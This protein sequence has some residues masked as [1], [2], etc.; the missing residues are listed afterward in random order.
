LRE[1]HRLRVFE[2]R[3]L[4]KFGAKRDKVTWERRKPHNEELNDLYSSPTIARAIKSTSMKCA[5]SALGQAK[6]TV[7]TI[8]DKYDRLE[9][10]TMTG[11]KVSTKSCDVEHMEKNILYLDRGLE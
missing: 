11:T 1:E 10:S 6:S 3:V 7:R 9:G 8:R 5:Y 4:R 2:N